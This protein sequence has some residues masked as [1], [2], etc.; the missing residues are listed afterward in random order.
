MGIFLDTLQQSGNSRSGNLQFGE[1]EHLFGEVFQGGSD[2]IDVRSVDYQEAVV[3]LLVG[4]DAY[5]E[6]LAVVG[7]AFHGWQRDA[8]EEVYLA[9]YPVQALFVCR[10]TF[11]LDVWNNSAICACVSHTVSSSSRTSNFTSLSG[12]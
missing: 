12:W 7:D 6:I 1:S 3:A 11:C 9:V 2:V 5:R 10:L 8:N 4:V